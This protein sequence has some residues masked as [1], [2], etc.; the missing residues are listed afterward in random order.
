MAAAPPTEG[1]DSA[2]GEE[3]DREASSPEP[4]D[5]APATCARIGGLRLTQPAGFPRSP[6]VGELVSVFRSL[7]VGYAGWSGL[8]WPSRVAGFAG[9]WMSSRCDGPGFWVQ[10][11]HAPESME[12]FD[13][14]LGGGSLAS[15]G[16]QIDVASER[17]GNVVQFL[18]LD[19]CFV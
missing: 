8:P 1:T 18:E 12:R 16:H 6:T 3:R 15:A 14:V 17:S 19:Q 5:A 4:T 10:S 11:G 2:T 13:D 7:V 9:R